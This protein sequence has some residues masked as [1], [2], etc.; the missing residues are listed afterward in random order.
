MCWC[1]AV[2][3][4]M[5]D[6][7]SCEPWLGL[8]LH[9]PS[10]NCSCLWLYIV[11]MSTT[12]TMLPIR[13]NLSLYSCVRFNTDAFSFIITH[14]VICLTTEYFHFFMLPTHVY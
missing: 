12:C 14:H 7:G 11:R 10:S 5:V 13:C 6:S 8:H 2:M 4:F 1:T 9:T 3:L